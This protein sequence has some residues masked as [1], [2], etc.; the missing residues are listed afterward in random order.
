MKLK[1]FFFLI[2]ISTTAKAQ[3]KKD[4]LY[5]NKTSYRINNLSN[6]TELLILTSLNTELTN[7]PFSL[8]EIW[9]TQFVNATKIKLPF[10]CNICYF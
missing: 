10:N 4:T 1:L 6:D 2:I 5:I 7:L 8:K 9:I 3:I